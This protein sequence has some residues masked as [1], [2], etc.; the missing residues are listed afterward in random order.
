MMHC[1]T[2]RCQQCKIKSLNGNHRHTV[3]D[4]KTDGQTDQVANCII[5]YCIWQADCG[6][7]RFYKAR[8]RLA[9]LCIT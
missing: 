9:A 2:E 5:V 6:K 8:S 4:I 1:V 7:F 3:M